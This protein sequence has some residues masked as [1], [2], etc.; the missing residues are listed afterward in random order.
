[1]QPNLPIHF[2]ELEEMENHCKLNARS[3]VS[4]F[5]A[6]SLVIGI[7]T[8]KS[9]YAGEVVPT[10]GM[11]ITEDTT[12]Q[13]G[14]Y[15]LP[16]GISIGASNI[17]LNMNGAELVGNGFL[18]HGVSSDGFDNFTISN[19]IVNGYF[20][21]FVI[22]NS[23]GA[24]ILNN[25]LS[26]NW[27]D[28]ASQNDGAP[29]LDINAGPDLNDTTNLGG[30][31]F[32]NV[33]SDA[34]II[35][36]TLSN[37]ENG[38]DLF[39]VE[40]STI[41]G[42]NASNNTGWGIHLHSST[43][44]IV[45]EN[46]AD[47]CIRSPLNDSAGFLVV[48]GSH[49]NQFIG[50][51]FQYSGDGFFIGN[52]NG[53]PSNDNLVQSNNG[54]FAGAN[55]FEA[56]FSSGNQFIDNI[57]D[58]SNYGFWLGYSHSGNLIDSNSIRANNVN[59][60]EI[61]HG[62]NNTIAGNSIIGN[63]GNAIVLRTDG[64]E[65]FPAKQYPCLELP[66]QTTSRNY[67][68]VSNIIHSNFGIGLELTDTTDSQIT[69]NLVAAN[70]GGTATSNGAI[71]TWSIDPTKG[72]NIVDGPF[73]GGNY[74]DNYKG[75]DIDEDGLGDTNVPYT[76]S[77]QI[78]LPGD[79]HPLIGDPEI[80]G[81]DNPR[82]MC[83]RQWLDLGPNTRSGGGEF[84]TSNGTHF[85]TD[86]TDLYLLE[87]SNSDRLSFFNTEESWYEPRAVLPESVWDG[88]GFVY[89][90]GSYYATVGTQF[91][92]NNGTGK[93]PKLYAY[94]PVGDSWSSKADTEVAGNP[95]ANEALAYDS[96]N[97]LIYAS[98]VFV[99]NEGDP[100]LLK[101]LAIYDP[102]LDIWIG[103]TSPGEFTFGVGSEIE[104]LDG[105]IYVWQGGFSGGAV[106]GS[107]SFLHVYDINLDTWSATPTLQSSGVIPG[108]RSGAFDIWGVAI[109]S[110]S[111][112]GLIFVTGGETNRQLY[113]FDVAT[114]SWAVGPIAVYDG[115]WGDGLE[116]VATSQTFYQI[117]GRTGLGNVQGTAA[118]PPVSID[119]NG[120]GFVGTGDLLILFSNWGPC[121]CDLP[122]SCSADFN[123]DGSI[124][125]GDL[126]ILF[127]NWGP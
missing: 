102:A 29:F 46:I 97:N 35:G 41:S 16:N 27:V 110:D 56:T 124:S 22:Q 8:T 94:D 96:I 111:D 17:T 70:L 55:A 119:L 89:A 38:M 63:G 66:D 118:L 105:K 86:G 26:E 19:G 117:D 92:Q 12:F 49:N 120:D 50:N 51:S 9:A 69:N 23:I 48:M 99:T 114:E 73:L 24:Q 60:I 18:N 113:V 77:G 54:S 93:G 4:L 33:V 32:M 91:D 127:V 78:E 115:G 31:L 81:F 25:N 101:S 100:T 3:L 82:T 123:D 88:G 13:P 75:S 40:N 106:N 34:T 28:P 21:G 64:I 45:T 68:V 103:T 76:N 122:G 65:H 125:T 112:N 90:D 121:D 108:F 15:N 85:A 2:K 57:A 62:Q 71:N 83:N 37:Q 39:F 58:G 53:C 5:W 1:M 79:L 10:D 116:Y 107:D 84:D 72:L 104:Y 44:N 14:T 36:N 126:L 47:H 95:V 98:V 67:E 30:G 59:G 20:Y 7:I 42:N 6:A 43:G 74:W 52:E 11:V 61:E 109:A 87:G 80:E